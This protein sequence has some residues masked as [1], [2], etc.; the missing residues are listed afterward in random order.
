MNMPHHAS[1]SERRSLEP[2]ILNA[3]AP[4]AELEAR[5]QMFR[6]Q[7]KESE[8]D[9]AVITAPYSVFYLSGIWTGFFA[10]SPFIIIA[11]KTYAV[12]AR[13]LDLAWQEVWSPQSWAGEWSSYRDEDDVADVVGRIVRKHYASARNSLGLELNTPRVSERFAARLSVF[14]EAHKVIDLQPSMIALRSVKS[15]TELTH[16][17]RSS[18]ITV[19]GIEA[20]R[21]SIAGGATDSASAAA[22]FTAMIEAGSEPLAHTPVVVSGP[23]NRFTHLPWAG[24]RPLD[25]EPTT[26][27]LGAL[28]KGYAA[29]LER[30]FFKHHIP[31]VARDMLCSVAEAIEVTM[32]QLR[33]GMTGAEVDRLAR[34]VHEKN[35]WADRFLHRTGYSTGINWADLDLM[36]LHPS[37]AATVAPG[38]TFHL[39]PHLVDDELG[40]LA[41]SQPIVVTEHGC[42]PLLEFPL[43][44]DAI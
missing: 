32:S 14:A 11:Q 40:L 42:E 37:E 26:M 18:V 34:S 9:V 8:V 33:P 31:S 35:G 15:S 19:R 16:M 3:A 23:S 38:M 41:I 28:V 30:T 27:M 21:D 4:R 1:L 43:I 5:L 7:L 20:A 13:R 2:Q 25:G 24:V 22:A 29:P 39:V 17:K 44:V 6:N 12:I 36:Q 10:S